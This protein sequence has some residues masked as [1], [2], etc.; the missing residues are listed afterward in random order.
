MAGQFILDRDHEQNR[1]RDWPNQDMEFE[2]RA[3][4][5]DS[6][7]GSDREMMRP[8]LFSLSFY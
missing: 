4:F 3:Y 6:N 1:H 7:L 5:G 8:I 2:E